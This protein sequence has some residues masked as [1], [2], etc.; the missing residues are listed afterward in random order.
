MILAFFGMYWLLI[1]HFTK[2][3]KILH[4][5]KWGRVDPTRMDDWDMV[6]NGDIINQKLEL[7]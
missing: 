4:I 7:N 2:T 1:L 6:M 3:D 5:R